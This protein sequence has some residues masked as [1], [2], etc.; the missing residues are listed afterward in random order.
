M[1]SALYLVFVLAVAFG[2]SFVED[3]F[4]RTHRPPIL[5]AGAH[6]AS[7]FALVLDLIAWGLLLSIGLF[8]LFVR[9]I[10]QND[11]DTDQVPI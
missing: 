9:P 4:Q 1:E 3:L 6:Y 5:I 10:A 2:L 7:V 8:R 11:E